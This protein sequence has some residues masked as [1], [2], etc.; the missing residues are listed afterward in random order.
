VQLRL[1]GGKV[2]AATCAGPFV[3]RASVM[4][5]IRSGVTLDERKIAAAMDPHVALADLI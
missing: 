3:D 2:I 1:R 4:A 5:L